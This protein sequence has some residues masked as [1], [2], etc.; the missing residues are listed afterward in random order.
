VRGACA[1]RPGVP[2]L[3]K[4]IR[5]RSIVGRFL[6]HS[7][8]Y[9]FRNNLQHDV[10]LSSADWM[11]RNLYRRVEIAFPVYSPALKQRVLR[12]G[13]QVYLKDNVDAW[14]LDGD[15]RYRRRKPRGSQKP[16]SAQQQLM[17]ML[18]SD[19][20]HGTDPVAPRRS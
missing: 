19:N 5:V 13:L 20:E 15:G 14:E 8:I 12:E 18:G 4:N 17:E 1:L 10:W 3:S 16:H 7:R 9:Y 6:E 2:G 11:N